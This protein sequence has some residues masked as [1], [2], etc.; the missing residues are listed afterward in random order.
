MVTCKETNTLSE[1]CIVLLLV[2]YFYCI[3][4]IKL[5]QLKTSAKC[6]FAFFLVTMLAIIL[7]TSVELLGYSY[8]ELK[9]TVDT[10]LGLNVLSV[11]LKQPVITT[12]IVC[13]FFKNYSGVGH[14]WLLDFALWLASDMFMLTLCNI[15]AVT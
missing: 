8:V 4:Y 14:L 10:T 1:V 5:F 15:V 11:Y 3:L 9:I 12:C 13:R 2:S 7:R 6:V